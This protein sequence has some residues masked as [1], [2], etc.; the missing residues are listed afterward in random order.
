MADAELSTDADRT[1]DADR[2]T[3]FSG[4]VVALFLTQVFGAGLGIFSGILLARLLGPAEK[5]DYYILTLVPATA[6]VVLQL[7][8][9]RAF[10]FYTARGVTMTIVTKAFV[11]TGL[12]TVVAIVGLFVLLPLLQ[13]DIFHDIPIELIAFSFLSFP[14]AINGAFTIAIVMG[15]KGV[16]WYSGINVITS[17]AGLVFL[18]VFL[19]GIGPTVTAAI[20]AYV[21]TNLVQTV[22]SAIGAR[23]LT[24]GLP[25]VEK[26]TYRSL[27]R[28]GLPSYPGSLAVFFSYRVDAYLIAFLMLDSATALGYYSLAVGLAEIVFFFPRAVSTLYFPHV[29]GAPREESARQVATMSR[30]TLLVTSVS[31]LLMAPAAAVMVFLVLPAYIPSL[32]ALF[33]LLPGVVVFS[34]TFVANGYLTGIDRVGVTSIVSVISVVTNVIAN[35][36]LIPLFGIVGA[37]TASLISYSFS[38]VL[39]TIIASRLTTTPIRRFWLPGPADVRFTAATTIAVLARL[40]RAAPALSGD[41]GS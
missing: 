5:G 12:L 23:R 25:K 30:V 3:D 31:A 2:S 16:R 7:G 19:I 18:I 15:R 24:A 33:V 38:S 20:A 26:V 39:L 6:M 14:L 11:L 17:I 36:I 35:L 37:A 1:A 9:P 29:A 32:P 34:V 10:G 41:P 28:Y 40:R 22:G 27:F 8:L 21:A 4:G 13:A